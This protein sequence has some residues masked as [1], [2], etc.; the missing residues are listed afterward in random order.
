MT[1]PDQIL[2]K[3]LEKEKEARDFYE[4][5]VLDCSVDFVRDQLWKIYLP[6]I[7]AVFPYGA[8]GGKLTHS[9]DI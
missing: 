8:I 6:D 3:A 1:T 4:G 7:P 2:Q 9:R 5:L